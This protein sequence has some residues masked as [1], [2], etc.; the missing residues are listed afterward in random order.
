MP[1]PRGARSEPV[2]VSERADGEGS[3]TLA[4]PSDARSLAAARES[5]RRHLAEAGVDET[6]AYAVDLALEEL[7]GNA[8]RYGYD[9]GA[10]GT[11]Q[12]EIAVAP[13]AVAMSIADDARPFDPTTHPEPKRAGSLENAPTGGRGISMVRRVVR[14]MRYERTSDGNRVDLDVARDA[15]AD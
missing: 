5:V 10:R 13:H 6:A 11:I 8:L 7:A 15:R 14:G 9:A 2:P 1:E 12:V 4:F 3:I